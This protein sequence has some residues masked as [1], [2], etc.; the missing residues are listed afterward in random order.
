MINLPQTFLSYKIHTISPGTGLFTGGFNAIP[1]PSHTLT[2]LARQLAT[3]QT[4]QLCHS[5]TISHTTSPHLQDS[6]D[7]SS[8]LLTVEVRGLEASAPLP[9]RRNTHKNILQSIF[10]VNSSEPVLYELDQPDENLLR[11]N[12]VEIF[13]S[14][15]CHSVG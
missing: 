13:T 15:H 11:F 2:T 4:L 9:Q 12:M 10:L 8:Q 3:L 1:Q 5:P 14:L 6:P 7:S